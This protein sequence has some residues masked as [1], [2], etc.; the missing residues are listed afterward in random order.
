VWHLY[1]DAARSLQVLVDLSEDNNLSTDLVEGYPADFSL[2]E[3]KVDDFVLSLV[4]GTSDSKLARQF[5]L[6][7]SVVADLKHRVRARYRRVF[8]WVDVIH[9]DAAKYGFIKNEGRRFFVA[10]LGSSD[11]YK[12]QKAMDLCVRW[13]LQY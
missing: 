5:L 11:L 7:Q 1:P 2:L 12:R 10:G 13:L 4:I 6:K 3:H 9:T 8:H